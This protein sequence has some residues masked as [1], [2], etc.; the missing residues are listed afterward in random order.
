MT[1]LLA[2]PPPSL[3]RFL[4]ERRDELNRR[5]H[6]LAQRY[7]KLDPDLVLLTLAEILP[8]LCSAAEGADEPSAIEGLLSSVYDLVLLHTGRDAFARH[9]GLSLLLRETL[10]NPAVRRLALLDPEQLPAELSN[11]VENLD[12]RGRDFASWLGDLAAQAKTPDELRLAGAVLAWR[13]GEAR[14]RSAGLAALEVLGPDLWLTALGEQGEARAIADSLGR[15]GWRSPIAEEPGEGYEIVA[16][17]GAFAGFGGAFDRP[18]ELVITDADDVNDRHHFYVRV[19]QSIFRVEADRFG[20]SIRPANPAHLG[21][22]RPALQPTP[23]LSSKVAFGLSTSGVLLRDG[24]ETKLPELEGATSYLG[25]E[26]LVVV[27][28]R[29]S[30]RIR[31]LVP[32]PAS[33]G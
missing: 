2:S 33:R 1:A 13:L 8:P 29:D 26:R 4:H 12:K 27:T 21:A 22:V 16:R 24:V 20:A 7:P 5:F 14:L 32:R 23:K 31:V 3:R 19:E 30:H 17:L 28:L 11:A 15:E 6:K 10:H 9:P 25:R 18:P